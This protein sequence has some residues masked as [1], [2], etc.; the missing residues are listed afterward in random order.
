MLYMAS[1]VLICFL[2]ELLSGQSVN[3]NEKL[4]TKYLVLVGL[5]IL[6]MVGLR[7]PGNGSGDTQVYCNYWRAA[8]RV[9]LSG[10]LHF[11]KNNDFEYGFQLTAWI[12]ARLFRN[13]QWMLVLSGAFFAVSV[14]RFA[15]KNCGDVVLALTVFNCLG[16]FNFMV[17]GMRQAIAMCICLWAVE[18]CKKK[19]FLKFFLLVALA[20]TFHA[21]AVVFAAIFLLARLKLNLKSYL[22]VAVGTVAAALLLSR[23][24]E[25]VNF[26]INDHYEMGNGAKEG[27]VVAIAIYAA[28][29]IFGLLVPDKEDE[30]YPLFVYMVFVSAAALIMRNTVS[31]IVER[32]GSYFAFGEMVVVSNSVCALKSKDTKILLSVLVTLL[33]LGVAVHKASYSELIPYTFFWQ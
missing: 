21:S 24:F 29:L 4:K 6:L 7:N 15:Q 18:Q 1:P 16:L 13:Q 30:S 11:F 22:L 5:A 19:H 12:L 26:F 14:C 9:P 31:T 20:A 17:Q 27:G 8:G 28:V 33:C 3:Q 32:I 25:I 2:L 23:L 10:V